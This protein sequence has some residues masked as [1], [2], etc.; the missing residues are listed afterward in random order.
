MLPPHSQENCVLVPSVNQSL[1]KQGLIIDQV[2]WERRELGKP[3]ARLQF[4]PQHCNCKH[5]NMIFQKPMG[6]RLGYVTMQPICEPASGVERVMS[7]QPP[8]QVDMWDGLTGPEMVATPESSQMIGREPNLAVHRPSMRSPGPVSSHS[9][10]QQV[11]AG[12]HNCTSSESSSKLDG[13][14]SLEHSGL[15]TP[16]HYQQAGIPQ[17][18]PEL[19]SYVWG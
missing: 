7:H 13:E 17:C 5:S 8:T 19:G 16:T 9:R 2:V 1:A 14:S 6:V 12:L 4:F 18:L 10:V 3:A 11:E 15:D